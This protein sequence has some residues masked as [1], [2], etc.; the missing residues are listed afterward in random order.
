MMD[1]RSV[2]L[3]S[4]LSFLDSCCPMDKCVRYDKKLKKKKFKSHDKTQ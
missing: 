1:K 2:H 3:V 4:R